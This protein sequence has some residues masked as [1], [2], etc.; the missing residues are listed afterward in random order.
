MTIV[1]QTVAP[2]EAA[3]EVAA[4]RGIPQASDVL[5]RLLRCPC[6]LHHQVV[7]DRPS[8]RV[9]CTHEHCPLEGRQT[10]PIVDG[11]PILIDFEHS[12]VDEAVTIQGQAPCL[13]PRP[14]GWQ[15]ALSRLI[16]GDKPGA[17]RNAARF[18]EL[19]NTRD[20]D[21]LVLVIGGAQIGDGSES[22]YRRDG[23][24]I[25]AFDVYKS[26]HTQFVADAH[27]IPISDGQVDGVWIQAV[28]EHV[29]SPEQVV[30]E[31]GRVLKPGGL[32]YA[33][34]AFMQQVHEG[35]YDFTRFT[36]SGHR[37]LFRRFELIDSGVERGPLTAVL[38][39]IR[40]ALAGLIRSRNIATLICLPFFWLRYLD[41]LMPKSYAVDAACD[42]YF[43]GRKS[44][45]TLRPKDMIAAYAGAQRPAA[46]RAVRD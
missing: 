22:L 21:R 27:S 31:I 11:Q 5:D 35:P 37:W 4:G 41:H 38:W 33:E 25:I 24:R 36:E 17:R 15:K 32:V 23:A 2:V 45:A 39:S 12:I 10:F 20:R 1:K 18:L 28:L 7:V 19:L 46:R 14:V 9:V 26:E 34:T 40:Y 29:L 42:V 3:P 43:L 16:F 30:L 8:A 6:P 44:G 13:V